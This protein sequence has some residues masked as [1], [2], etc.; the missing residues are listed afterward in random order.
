MPLACWCYVLGII[1]VLLGAAIALAPGRMT[2]VY[3]ALPRNRAAGIVLSTVAWIWAGYAVWMMGLDF[4]QPFKMYIPVA[5]LACIPLTWFW[6]DN[7]LPCRAL[8]G[9]L[10]LFPYELLHAARVHASPWRLLVVT[11]AYL[12]IV[13]GMILLLYP[14][15][16]RQAIEWVTAR[17]ALFRLGGMINA[18]LG[19]LLIA[20]GA[21]VL[22]GG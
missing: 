3:R 12:C 20:V 15:K 4:M 9:V 16:M 10:V 21:T 5:V 8:G 6:L 18:L 22:R 2:R 17:P 13:K 1:C 11:V 7:L 14:W 19:L